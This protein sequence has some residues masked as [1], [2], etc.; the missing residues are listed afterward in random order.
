MEQDLTLLSVAPNPELPQ[1]L[2]LDS[3]STH[4]SSYLSPQ[5]PSEVI[6]LARSINGSAIGQ[7]I[8]RSGGRFTAITYF[9][10]KVQETLNIARL[11]RS[12]LHK[13][14]G[15]GEQSRFQLLGGFSAFVSLRATL[16][17]SQH[18]IPFMPLVNLVKDENGIK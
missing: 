7:L 17:G 14:A 15:T 13:K 6:S 4:P 3:A 10:S 11:T 12:R 5:T 16:D 2:Q 1:A 18:S 9:V 8:P